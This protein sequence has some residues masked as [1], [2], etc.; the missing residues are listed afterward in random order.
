MN[1]KLVNMVFKIGL[2]VIGMAFLVV[3]FFHSKNG[4]FLKFGAA[5][6]LH[7]LDTRS[8]VI[9]YSFLPKQGL[10]S[11]DPTNGTVKKYDLNVSGEW[12]YQATEPAPNTT[13]PPAGTA[14][15]TPSAEDFL[16]GKK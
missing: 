4:R 6:D 9:Y 7:V 14:P 1:E 2:L 5:E 16:K 13:A 3:Y 10:A 8:G 12:K 15:G 11:F